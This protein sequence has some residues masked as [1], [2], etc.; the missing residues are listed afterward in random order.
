MRNVFTEYF[1]KDQVK[2]DERDKHLAGAEEIRIEYRALVG[3]LQ[4]RNYFG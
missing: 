1:N 3:S 2:Q 4:E